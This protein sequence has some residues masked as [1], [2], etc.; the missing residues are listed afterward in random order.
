MFGNV[1]IKKQI[2]LLFAFVIS[3]YA[4]NS[5][6]YTATIAHGTDKSIQ[7]TGEFMLIDQKEKLQIAT[8][9]LA[10]VIGHVLEDLNDPAARVATIRRLIKD[11]RF[12]D[13]R[14]S[15]F[16]VFEKTTTVAHPVDE[17]L[18]GTDMESVRDVNG[19]Y[20]VRE[21]HQAAV[22]GGGFVSYI[23]KK[24]G[25]G[26]SPKISYAEMIPGTSMWLGTGI[27]LD[28]IAVFQNEIAQ[29][30]HDYSQKE[31]RWALAIGVVL[32]TAILVFC[33]R[34]GNSISR[35]I[36]AMVDFT[37]RLAG[38]DFTHQ[39]E[40]R[41]QDEIGM[42][43]QAL[44]RMVV[45]LSALFKEVTNGVGTL[46]SS[47]FQV[48]ELAGK[49][50]DVSERTSKKAGT[51]AA[52]SKSMSTHMGSVA[53][54]SEQA[55]T[56]VQYAA[57][58]VEEMSATVKEIAKNSENARHIA[59]A[60]AEKAG[61]VSTKVDQLG[62]AAMA[63]S[64]VTE[65]INEISDQTNLLALNATIEAARA[66]EAGKG[67]AVVAN[68][69]KELAR[70]T[71]TATG[72]IKTKVDSIQSASEETV[73]DIKAIA[74]V[75][76]EINETIGG[77]A[78]A[79]EEQSTATAEIS[80]NVVQASK[81]IEDVNSNITESAEATRRFAGEIAEITASAEEIAVSSSQA[82]VSA[83]DLQQLADRLAEAMGKFKV[84]VQV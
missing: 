46:K 61:K 49:L 12:E 20:L 42:A 14:S 39:M 28:N 80:S 71:A 38:G 83:G 76:T 64:K 82:S 68:E 1:T 74:R 22:K 63:I 69:I 55:T 13:D 18:Q 8:H 60:A 48:T 6:M 66:G 47:S 62:S 3:L 11:V 43:G 50:N 75:I 16:F 34:I 44:N 35:R 31:A 53:T 25:A 57:S 9:S 52:A 37:D 79:V 27:Y 72:E 54:A 81:G 2:Y 21:L 56:N 26:D 17:K 40:I 5:V 58:S 78:A 45:K 32:L 59:G 19:V 23:W 51:V 7:K 15:Y 77:I 41:R 24:P 36:K 4:F 65:V 33:I 30:L 73:T 84:Q 70:Q 29:E 10:L 67:F